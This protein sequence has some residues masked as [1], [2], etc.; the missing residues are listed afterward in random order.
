MI[1]I[2]IA[3]HAE[4]VSWIDDLP[5]YCA[6]HLYNCGSPLPS[7]ALARTVRQTCLRETRSVTSAYLH[8]LIHHADPTDGE[9]TVFTS[10]D[11]FAHAPAWFELLLQPQRWG[12]VQ[13]LSVIADE[14]LS[15]PPRSLIE[16]DCR[17]WI[18]SAA[19]RAE[20]FSLA[21]LAP[22]GFHDE[23]V[24][25]IARVYRQKQGISEGVHL[26]AHFL[27]LCGFERLA[28][29]AHR[30]DMGVFAYGPVFAVRH[31]RLAH[32]LQEARAHLGKL[33]VMARAAPVYQYLFERAWLHLFGLP[34]VRFEPLQR[35]IDDAAPSPVTATSGQ[36]IALADSETLQQR[37]TLI[38]PVEPPGVAVLRRR[39]HEALQQGHPEDAQRL[40]MQALLKEPQNLELLTEVAELAFQYGDFHAAMVNARQA[41]RLD[42][43]HTGCQFVL[44]M[45][46]AACGE[47]QEALSM[48]DTLMHSD[49]TRA[50]REQHPEHLDMA[51][52]EA[53][54]LMA[55]LEDEAQ[56]AVA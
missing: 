14:R 8:H 54:R 27:Y 45:A 3:R 17:D 38:M 1:N 47:S 33:D 2:V 11:P 50:F 55:E 25:S 37:R 32:F 35:P 21:T 43:Q 9:F 23:R 40:L 7:D 56:R 39:A 16:H 4:D 18:G 22:M 51:E 10:G 12:D 30:S 29:Q 42:P 15:L 44:A 49:T 46:L 52:Q 6:V 13:P 20:R 24:P 31:G 53:R 19:V 34:F 48:F 28:E 5:S 41:L 26:M 36:G